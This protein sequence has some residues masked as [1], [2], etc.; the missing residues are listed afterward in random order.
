MLKRLSSQQSE[1]VYNAQSLREREA[2]ATMAVQIN[3]P[4]KDVFNC[5]IW[6]A[7]VLLR[8]LCKRASPDDAIVFNNY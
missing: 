5:L 4:R 6:H 2:T 7:A 8:K 3:Q 1:T